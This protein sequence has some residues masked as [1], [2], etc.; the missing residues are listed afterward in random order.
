MRERIQNN[1]APDQRVVAV[2]NSFRMS[3]TH[4]R[5]GRDVIEKILTK[6]K[7][8]HFHIGRQRGFWREDVCAFSLHVDQS[9]KRMKALIG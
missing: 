7:L 1:I 5:V 3:I 4:L 9:T 6:L 2:D 8:G